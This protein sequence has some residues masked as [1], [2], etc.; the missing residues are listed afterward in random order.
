MYKDRK[1][2]LCS[3]GNLDLYPSALRFKKQ[4]ESFNIFDEIF[5]YNEY[6]LPYDEKFE[7]LLRSKLV[8][9]RGFGYWCWKPFI[10]LKTLES[11]ND[12]DILFYIDMGCHLNKEGIDRFYEYLDIVIENLNL[13]FE[14]GN[15]EK[16]WTKS[17][18]FNYFN[19]LNNS[20]IT[21]SH[22]IAATSFFLL[23]NDVNIEFVK[24]WLQVYYDDF[25]LVD[26][27]PSKI[28]NFEMFSE[29]RH[30]QSIFSILSKLYH[31]YTIPEYELE[32]KDKK[33]PIN[34][35][36]DKKTIYS[37]ISSKACDKFFDKLVWYIPIR[38][39]RD[40]IR[41]N[42]RSYST[43]S[44]KKYLGIKELND[45]AITNINIVDIFLKHIIDK[46]VIKYIKSNKDEINSM[47]DYINQYRKCIDRL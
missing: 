33:Y 20:D 35:I 1:I 10:V 23:R 26:N 38:K 14:L 40:S 19:V 24:K 8:P 37:F 41:S 47:I 34:A 11:M 4:A 16:V 36:R 25:S 15:V 9:S 42:L 18:L 29:H 30:D 31:F 39:N 21:D 45:I 27:T 28:Q 32:I 13:C 44:V 12:D 46:K 17:D 2:Y 7:R 6:N 3:F 5:I 43:Y 22:Q